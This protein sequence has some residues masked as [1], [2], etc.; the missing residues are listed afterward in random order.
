MTSQAAG[1][2]ALHL[3]TTGQGNVVGHPIMPVLKIT[4]NP[5][6][7]R[8]MDEHIDLDISGILRRDMTLDEAGER[9]IDL[10]LRACNGRMTAAEVLGHREFSMHR[11]HPS[12]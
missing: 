7:G 9:I 5:V 11:V 10:M 12:A 8:T 4:A 1:E 3:F 2:F 6:T